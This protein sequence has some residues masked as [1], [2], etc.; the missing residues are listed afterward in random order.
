M[1]RALRKPNSKAELLDGFEEQLRRALPTAWRAQIAT[2]PGYGAKRPD[3]MLRITAPDGSVSTLPVEVKMGMNT[4]DV[5]AVLARLTAVQRE[6]SLEDELGAPLVVSRYLARS[7]REELSNVGISYA[8]ATGNLKLIVDRPAVYLEKAGASADP[9]RGPDRETRSLRGRPASRVV[10]ALIDF[11][12]PVGIR[13]LA[14]RAQ[15][16]VGSTYRTVDFLDKEALIDRKANG[17]IGNVDWRNLLNRWSEDYGFQKR[18][19]IYTFL[20]P[21]GPRAVI[22]ALR[23]R[24]VQTRYAV[25]GSLSAIRFSEIAEPQSAAIFS[26][27][28]RALAEELG[29]REATGYPNVLLAVPFD[30]VVFDRADDG[31]G[32]AYAALSQTAA[33]LLTGPGREPSEGDALLDWM[34]RNE[35]AWRR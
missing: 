30:D 22:E 26:S 2:E 28:P 25:T 10:R 12:P 8:D 4:R 27:D 6:A 34:T 33:D 18:N 24:P 16:S 20:E 29:L 35:D 1:D 21:R 15:T 5:P 9:W 19:S 23:E 11:R 14:E 13:E 3:A 31:A 32:V 17:G 7:T